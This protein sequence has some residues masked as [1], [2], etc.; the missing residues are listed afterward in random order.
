MSWAAARSSGGASLTCSGSPRMSRRGG[1]ARG[2]WRSTR[3]RATEQA[4]GLLHRVHRNEVDAAPV[5]EHARGLL[6]AAFV[7]DDRVRGAIGADEP[8]DTAREAWPT[9]ATSS[10]PNGLVLRVLEA[11]STGEQ[12]SVRLL[13]GG[14]HVGRIVR[15]TKVGLVLD[16]GAE[17]AMAGVRAIAAGPPQPPRRDKRDRRLAA[18]AHAFGYRGHCLTKSR[19]WSTTFTNVRQAREDYVR[20]QLIAKGD[21]VQ[22][23]LAQL[24]DAERIA[25]FEFVGVGHLTTADA[26]LAAQ[27]AARARENRELA[28]EALCDDRQRRIERGWEATRREPM[29]LEVPQP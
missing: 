15:R 20:E 25:A 26:W 16:T 28:R 8:S 24:D 21:R 23:E 18:C 17:V 7:L 3:R 9:P 19:R 1:G 27:A 12:V 13:D 2:I 22:R 5:R 29:G 14:E 4:G 11:M 10:D 6:H